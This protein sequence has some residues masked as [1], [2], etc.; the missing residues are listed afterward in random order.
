MDSSGSIEKAGKGN[1][2]KCLDFIKNSVNGS[3]ISETFTH[4]GLVLFSSKVCSTRVPHTSCRIP[5]HNY[6]KLLVKNSTSTF[7]STLMKIPHFDWLT[8]SLSVQLIEN[9]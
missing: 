8:N 6:S 2:K 9:E 1:Y 5:D 3:F 4:V 7:T